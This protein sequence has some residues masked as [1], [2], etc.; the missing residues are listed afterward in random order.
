MEKGIESY[1]RYLKGDQSAMRSIVELYWDNMLLFVNGYIHNMTEA[2]DIAQDALIQL[3]TKRPRLREEHQLRAYLLKT[4]RNRALNYLKKH[5]HFLDT[6]TEIED[7]ADEQ[8]IEVEDRMS[9]DQ[10]KRLL[11]RAIGQLK[12]EYR[13]VIYLRYFEDL[14]AKECAAVMHTTEKLVTTLAYQAR[15]Q[16]K[17]YLEKEGYSGENL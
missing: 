13:E 9:L 17:K 2:E 7:L 11:H 10:S 12:Q 15:Q 4:C 5:R 14:S 3:A 16:L 8:I 6:E 1:L